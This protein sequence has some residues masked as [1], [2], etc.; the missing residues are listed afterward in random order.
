[1][2]FEALID[3]AWKQVKPAAAP[4]HPGVM[5]SYRV[6][7]PLPSE[8]PMTPKS[9]LVRWVFAAGMDVG[10]HDAERV[11]AP[12]ARVDVAADGTSNLTVISKALE[13]NDIQG[14]KPITKAEA[15]MVP[16]VFETDEALRAGDVASVKEPWCRW[17]R[18]NGVIATKL[19]P[20]HEAFFTALACDAK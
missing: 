5:W 13:G 16:K 2:N 14:V 11:A 9:T 15:D 7:P 10:L 20:K 4:K 1:M 8:W 18:Y 6:A 12:W 17:L 19:K 3:P